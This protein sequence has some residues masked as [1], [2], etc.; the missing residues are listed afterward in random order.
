MPLDTDTLCHKMRD[1]FA[2]PFPGHAIWMDADD[3]VPVFESAG[4]RGDF[5]VS[6]EPIGL[7]LDWAV[8]NYERRLARHEV[9]G[10]DAIPYPM[11]STGTQLFA[12]A[13]GCA[14]HSF[15]DSNPCALPLVQ[16][17]AEADALT[18]PSLEEPPLSRV[19]ELGRLVRERV[20]PEVP[21]GVPDIQSALDIAALVWRK[22]DLFLAMIADPDAVQ[23]LASK[24]QQLLIAF[25]E[26]FCQELG[27]INYCHCPYAWA[28]PDLGVWLS[29]DEAGS[30]STPMFDRF[31]LPWLVE[32]SE[33]FG[34][35][36]MHCCADADHQYRSFAKIPNLYGLNRVFQEPGPRPAIDAFS[37]HTVLMQAWTPLDDAVAM[38][39]IARPNTRFLFNMPAQ[40]LDDARR[41]LD[42][43]R[44][45]CAQHEATFQEQPQ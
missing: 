32:L 4:G 30:I 45:A 43:L 34:G 6:D 17:P 2:G 16:T 7:W 31:C 21:I 10:D 38:L 12:A 44:E 40:P 22:E 26:R 3:V 19:F 23:R 36:F 20:G 39:E 14:V 18:V 11:L 5:T 33:R 37:G 29:E 8:G 27:E 9:L 42:A 15:E 41:T 13:F 1:L 24:C 28:P 25:F 35:L